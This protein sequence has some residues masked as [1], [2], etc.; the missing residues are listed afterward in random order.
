M[1]QGCWRKLRVRACQVVTV[2]RA[3]VVLWLGS[4]RHKFSCRELRSYGREE[5]ADIC[6]SLP[7]FFFFLDLL[8]VCT[9]LLRGLQTHPGSNFMLPLIMV[10][11]FGIAV[12]FCSLRKTNSVFSSK[13]VSLSAVKVGRRLGPATLDRHRAPGRIGLILPMEGDAG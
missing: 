3:S 12:S 8:I 11:D 2:E 10:E 9:K 13:P 1:R 5:G 6:S 4:T 7:A